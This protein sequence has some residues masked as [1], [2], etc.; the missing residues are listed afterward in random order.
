MLENQYA[1]TTHQWVQPISENEVWVGITDPAQEALGDVVY[2]ELP[3]AGKVVNAGDSIGQIE[4]VKAASDIR[5]PVSGRLLA[6]NLAL[7]ETPEQVNEA[8]YQTWV[9]H[10]SVDPAQLQQ[11]LQ[12]LMAPAAYARW[13]EQ[14]D[15]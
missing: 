9:Y 2:I 12:A 4:S 15:A 5:S 7:E 6:C 1:A 13:L 8:P 3:D 10:F 11:E 14:Q